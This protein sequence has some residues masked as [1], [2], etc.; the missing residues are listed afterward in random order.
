MRV[1]T[2]IQLI[3]GNIELDQILQHKRVLGPV[4]TK[5]VWFMMKM[6]LEVA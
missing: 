1:C 6:C 3:V 2:V 5:D 4:G